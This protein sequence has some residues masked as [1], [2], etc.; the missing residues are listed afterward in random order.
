[1]GQLAWLGSE[2]EAEGVPALMAIA[3]DDGAFSF[4]LLDD[5]RHGGEAPERV[6]KIS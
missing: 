6:R 5:T 4:L 3:G 1:M 2:V